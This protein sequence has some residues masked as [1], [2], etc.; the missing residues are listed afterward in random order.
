LSTLSFPLSLPD[1]LPIY[2]FFGDRRPDLEMPH[3][4]ARA[5]QRIGYYREDVELVEAFYAADYARFGYPA[6]DKAGLRE[7]PRV[8]LRAVQADRKS[9]RLNSVTVKSRM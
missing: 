4:N 9:T 8:R 7:D 2:A 5:P 3:I 1:A 6:A